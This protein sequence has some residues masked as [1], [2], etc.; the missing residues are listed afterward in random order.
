MTEGTRPLSGPQAVPR[1]RPG[2]GNLASPR[3]TAGR[4]GHRVDAFQVGLR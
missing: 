2:A 1:S 4:E 3:R